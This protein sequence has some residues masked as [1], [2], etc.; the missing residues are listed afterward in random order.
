MVQSSRLKKLAREYMAKHPE[1]KYQQALAAVTAPDPTLT[2]PPTVPPVALGDDDRPE[3]IPNFFEALGIDDIA[4]HDFHA[5]WARG[6]ET[7][8]LRIP[9][10][11]VCDGD[12]LTPELSYL[13]VI[14][15]N[16]GGNGPHGAFAG[17][18][19]SGKSYLLRA[20]VLALAALY[21]PEDVAFV[22]ADF[23]GGATFLGMERL[24][25][26]AV[27]LTDL[28]NDL[29]AFNRLIAFLEGEVARREEFITTEKGC[30]NIG[31]YR[32][33]RREHSDSD[34][35][36]ALPHMIVIIDEFGEFLKEQPGCLDLLIRIG[37]VG[38][39][40]GM[41]LLM[42]SQF[43]DRSVVGDLLEHMSFRIALALN[44]PVHSVA[45][46]GTDD[47]ATMIRGKVKGKALRK[48]RTDRVPV[49]VASLH[50]EGPVIDP[51]TGQPT[52]TKMAD[53]LI[54]RLSELD[55]PDAALPWTPTLRTPR[56]LADGP[57]LQKETEGLRIRIGVLDYPE[58]HTMLSWCL[59]FNERTPHFV[60]AGGPKSG[61]STTLRTMVLTGALTHGPQRLAFML[62]DDADEAL[63]AVADAPNVAACVQAGDLAG[64]GAALGEVDRLIDLR[65]EAMAASGYAGFDQYL[66]AKDPDSDDPYGY[67]V[68]GIDGI[69]TFLGE[70]RREQASRLRRIIESGHR[71]G[72]HLVYTADSAGSSNI[73]NEA[74]YTMEVPGTVQLPSMNYA[75]A[76]F[77]AEVRITLSQRIPGYQPG[78]SLDQVTL[79]QGRVL[80]PITRK[81]EQDRL[82]RGAPVYD[83]HDYIGET[84]SVAANLAAEMGSDRV[85]VITPDTVTATQRSR[86]R[87]EIAAV[88]AEID[89]LI[90][91]EAV[92]KQLGLILRSAELEAEVQRRGLGAR[93]PRGIG[94]RNFV[95]S[96]EA[97]VGKSWAAEILARA[98]H[99]AGA[100]EKPE[101]TVVNRHSLVGGFE[102]E[103]AKKTA[104]VLA[105]ASG[106][107]LYIDEAYD[108]IQARVGQPDPFGSEALDTLLQHM[109]N[110][111][112]DVTVVLAG[113]PEPLDRLLRENPGLSSR[114]HVRVDF[115]AFTAEQLWQ[116]LIALAERDQRTVDDDV[117]EPFLRLA[118]KLIGSE[119]SH[120]QRL[121]DR[122]GNIRFVRNVVEQAE[123]LA[124]QRLYTVE[125]LSTISD[126]ELV[127]LTAQDV[128]EAVRN[129]TKMFGTEIGDAA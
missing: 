41:H 96:G 61:R 116:A 80:V 29:D 118:H 43:I 4:T 75:G 76:K 107:V 38:R 30:G 42:S 66:A 82:S 8:S 15:E 35:W 20:V 72:V 50:H 102:G 36:P 95:F 46:I 52:D 73:G 69:G 25:H 59:D 9:F 79:L 60:I 11:Y 47:A 44:S 3:H 63:A 64:I 126:E 53:A 123:H 90:G 37:R 31:E 55:A 128:T 70:E 2:P 119:D 89:S 24:P 117:Q 99:S 103:G 87:K 1:V 85:P 32:Q 51:E 91:Q 94:G 106:G 33:K 45:M 127:Q 49:E 34:D 22:L 98:L 21:S 40:L 7:E 124:A 114:I 115:E 39:S 23:K 48:F 68:V 109:V 65:S 120:G 54:D 81:I 28:E 125:D 17:R 58:H 84:R 83:V 113:Y 105:Q 108:L 122:L 56:T 104:T 57:Q 78:R 111:P 100:I 101:V 93:T 92:K 10:G 14:E 112:G 12:E 74:H 67:V 71:A 5:A 121:I 86:R 77:P 97:G 27:N 19:G 110:R 62:L 26:V 18:T 13:N 88:R 16:L 6:G 129:I